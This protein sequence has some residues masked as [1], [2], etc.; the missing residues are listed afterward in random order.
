MLSCSS[1][2]EVKNSTFCMV[3]SCSL[4]WMFVPFPLSLFSFLSLLSAFLSL[5]KFSPFCSSLLP[6]FLCN[7]HFQEGYLTQLVTAF[8]RDQEEKIYVQHRLMEQA[9]N[10]YNNYLKKNATIYI[11]GDATYMAKD[12]H[13][14]FKKI[15]MQFE[16]VEEERA[17]EMLTEMRKV[18]R[19]QEDVWHS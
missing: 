3:M 11:C 8:S 13:T 5:S 10:I 2:V 1:V 16:G 7:T 4:L 9:E 6:F 12:V 18:H 15:L 17:E 19:Y 14:C